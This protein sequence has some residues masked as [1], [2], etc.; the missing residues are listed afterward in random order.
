MLRDLWTLDHLLRL[1]IAGVR[2]TIDEI[3]RLVGEKDWDAL[4]KA[5]V[6]LKYLESVMSTA[7]AWQTLVH[8]Q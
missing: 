2:V 7:A 6:K 3:T 4:R 8:N 5:A 1:A